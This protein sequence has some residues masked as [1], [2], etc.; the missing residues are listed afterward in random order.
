M[1]RYVPVSLAGLLLC[2]GSDASAQ[3]PIYGPVPSARIPTEYGDLFDFDWTGAN[4]RVVGKPRLNPEQT[5]NYS[6]IYSGLTVPSDRFAPY[7]FSNSPYARHSQN[8]V[9]IPHSMREVCVR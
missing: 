7:L 3:Q 1:T 6:Q 4:L 9:E 5:Y 8:E 2:I